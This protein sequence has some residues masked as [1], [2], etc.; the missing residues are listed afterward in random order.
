[1]L[2]T[3]RY[4][5]PIYSSIAFTISL[6]LISPI[7]YIRTDSNFIHICEVM[8]LVLNLHRAMFPFAYVQFLEINIKLD[9]I[10][11]Y[12]SLMKPLLGL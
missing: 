8:C 2:P 5:Q 1:M 4:T 3:L 7:F 10:I 12:I 6:Q 9:I 11:Y